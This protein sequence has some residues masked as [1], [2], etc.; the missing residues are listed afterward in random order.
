MPSTTTP[1]AV[2]DLW[3][4]DLPTEPGADGA[5]IEFTFFWQDAQ[6]WEGENFSVAVGEPD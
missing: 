3:F 1:I 6:R 5:G 4:A 2:F